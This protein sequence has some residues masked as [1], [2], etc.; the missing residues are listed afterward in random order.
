MKNFAHLFLVLFFFTLLLSCQD[1]A[2]DVGVDR[3]LEFEEVVQVGAFEPVENKNE[4]IKVDSSFEERRDSTVWKCTIET[5]SVV[6]GAEDFP[7]FNPNAAILWPGNLLQGKTLQMA[8]PEDIN[9]PRAG[10]TISIDINDGNENASFTVD[11]VSRSSIAQAMNNIISS[12]TGLVPANFVLEV[13]Q[14]HSQEHLAFAM[15]LNFT[16]QYASLGAQMSFREDQEYN[17]FLVKLNQSF[18]T[19][20]FDA[21]TSADGFFAPEVTAG[22]LAAYISADNPA[23]YISSVTYGRVYYMLIESSSSETE[24]NAAINLSFQTTSVGG[25]LDAST[26]YL[27]SLQEMQIK[28]IA[29]GGESKSTFLTF[30]IT[31][32]GRLAELFGESTDIRT[33]VPVSYTVNTVSTG[34]RVAVKLATQYDVKNC[35]PLPV[36]L[37]NPLVWFDAGDLKY[38]I[39]NPST[40][41]NCQDCIE[42]NGFFTYI[43]D[44]DEYYRLFDIAPA[45]QVVRKWRDLTNNG[46][47][48]FSL[49]SDPNTRPLY[50]AEAYNNKRPAV[51]FFFSDWDA[52]NPMQTQMQFSGSAFNGT[53]YTI[54]FV[55]EYPQKVNYNFSSIAQQRFDIYSRDSKYGYFM[56]GGINEENRR[57]TVGFDNANSVRFS[58]GSLQGVFTE[59]QVPKGPF[60]MAVRR[61]KTG[62]TIYVNGEE[63]VHNPNLKDHMINYEN[64]IITAEPPSKLGN[65]RIWMGEMKAFGVAASESMI[66]KITNKLRKKYGI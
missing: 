9:L 26:D 58:Q 28:M 38:D 50:I 64:A 48:A 43:A 22:D 13:E 10:G 62:S 21:P 11:Q 36:E 47:D 5:K 8:T 34:E 40:H 51:E 29:L 56:R 1:N 19:M 14:V 16:T 52:N 61:G 32:L 27:K 63:V 35:E 2:E 7:L 65:S 20:I 42:R 3:A 33:G 49:Q 4:T 37:P 57:I 60:V 18:Y 31:D 41:N 54:F 25:S 66:V 17:R 12:S 45:G 24:I 15:D 23:T 39:T 46:F 30:G 53:D 44:K 59:Y 6:E 55:V